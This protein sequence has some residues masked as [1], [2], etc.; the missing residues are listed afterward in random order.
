MRSVLLSAL[1][2]CG[3]STAPEKIPAQPEAPTSESVV[4]TVGKEWDKADQKVAASVAVARENADK[5]EVVK[6]EAGVALSF[7][8]APNEG[9]LALARQRAAKADQ[10]DY[11]S[12]V[13]YGKKLLAKIDS[14]WAKVQAD[15]KEAAR[16]SKL[17]DDRIASLTAEVERVKKDAAANIW[18]MTG[19]GLVVI[20][21]LVCAFA[22]PKAGIPII[23][24]G[25]FAGALPFFFDSPYFSII[26]GVSLAAVAGLGIWWFYDRVHDSVN[27]SDGK[28]R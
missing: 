17:K 2:L 16:I 5:P 27:K 20:G 24:C 10:K 21:G 8:P 9:E 18:T 1:V 25:A 7:L 22:S 3:C 12:A 15:Q 19:A 13:E 6:S 23:A 14:D 11:A 28:D 26:A 4:A